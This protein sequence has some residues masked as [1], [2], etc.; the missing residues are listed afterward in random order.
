MIPLLA[1][2]DYNQPNRHTSNAKDYITPANALPNQ[3]CATVD[4]LLTVLAEVVAPLQHRQYLVLLA[5]HTVTLYS[6]VLNL[7]V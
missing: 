1:A 4:E 7:I 2:I 6:I 5:E 3:L